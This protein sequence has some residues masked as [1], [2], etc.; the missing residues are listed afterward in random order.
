MFELAL[1][2]GAVAAPLCWRV[3]AMHWQGTLLFVMVFMVFEGAL[4]KWAFPSLQGLIYFVKDGILIV[5]LVGFVLS[6]RQRERG[7]HEQALGNLRILLSVGF[8]YFFL[9]IANT[10]SPSPL[11]GVMGLKNYMLYTALLFMVPYIFVSA[12]DLER[13]IGLYMALMIPVCVLGLI[14]FSSAQDSII[15]TYVRHDQ[16]ADMHIATFGAAT[17]ITRVRASGTFSYIGGF[18]T[19]VIAMYHLAFAF[20]IGGNSRNRS[21]KIAYVMLAFVIMAAFTTG[22]RTAIGST[23]LVTPITLVL[24]LFAGVVSINVALRLGVAALAIFV[25][26]TLY[27]LDAVD[28]FVARAQNSDSNV[29]RFFSPLVEFLWAV[30]HAP[31]LGVGIGTTHPSAGAI[32]GTGGFSQAWW[33]QGLFV[34]G[35]AARVVVEVGVPGFFLA[36]APRIVLLGVAFALVLRLRTPLFKSLS[37]S[38]AVYYMVTYFATVVNNPTGGLYYWFFAGMLF[39]MRGIEGRFDAGPAAGYAHGRRDYLTGHRRA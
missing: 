33:L 15:N 13:K 32:M 27:S 30:E 14:Q 26:A 38:I 3:M 12:E 22:S 6:Q 17:E 10:N 35:E 11:V 31:I 9:Q 8:I 23:L 7:V 21:T 25:M 1:L 29:D 19:F 24:C 39:C 18:A 16:E 4:R 2:A 36:F 20:V 34:E 37:A 28:A 5:A